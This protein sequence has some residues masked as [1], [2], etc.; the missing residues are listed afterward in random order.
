MERC[1]DFDMGISCKYKCI[2]CKYNVYSSSDID[3]GMMAVIEPHIC[4]DCKEV[5]PVLIGSYGNRFF[6]DIDNSKQFT[7]EE[8]ANFYKCDDCNSTNIKP[9]S[10]Y[11]RRCPK[12]NYRMKQDKNAPEMLWD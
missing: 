10:K 4:L 5:T 9:W 2:N 3:Y 6:P 8:I 1:L 11:N 7:E 12:C